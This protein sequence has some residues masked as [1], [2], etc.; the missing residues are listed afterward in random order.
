MLYV[1]VL[2]RDRWG[3]QKMNK[4][5]FLNL[6]DRL[7]KG[8]LDKESFSTNLLMLFSDELKVDLF[9]KERLGFDEF[10]FGASKS[11]EQ[12]IKIADRYMTNNISFICTKLSKEKIDALLLRYP[13]M[14]AIEEAGFVRYLTSKVQRHKGKVAIV[15]AGSSDIPVALECFWTLDSCGVDAKIFADVGVAG[16]HRFF[17]IKDE[18]ESFD[19]IVV[20]A[21][22][23]GALPSLVAGLF[24]HPV[25][26]V[27]TSVGYGTALNGFTPLFA[28]L[29]SC[30]NGVSVVNI[31]NGFGAALAA[32]RILRQK[33]KED[34]DVR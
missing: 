30:A 18:V 13:M 27:P 34:A 5:F 29:T 16:V 22:M 24:P 9:R 19:V 4:E 8:E 10:V 25:I 12:I 15:T 26:A 21:G 31:D 20:I 11:L 32:F 1:K 23:E 3:N 28:M 2:E 33:E 14:E 17:K 7:L 6:A